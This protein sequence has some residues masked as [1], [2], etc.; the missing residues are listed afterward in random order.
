MNTRGDDQTSANDKLAAIWSRFRDATLQRVDHLDEALIALLENRLTDDARQAAVRE[1]H[2]LAGAS[3]TFGFPNASV[4]ARDL[5]RRLGSTVTQADVPELAE[6]LVQLRTELEGTPSLPSA[7]R[8]DVSAKPRT[9]LLLVEDDA[10]AAERVMMEAEARGF[11]VTRAPAG[12]DVMASADVKTPAIG[13]IDLRGPVEPMLATLDAMHRRFP[14]LPVVMVM[15]G[16]TFR[17]RVEAARHGVRRYVDAPTSARRILDAVDAV[18]RAADGSGGTV[19]AVDDDPQILAAAESVLEERGLRF[20]S[21]SDPTRFWERLEETNPDLL[22]LDIDMPEVNGI[23]ACRVV[24]G[25]ARWASLPIVFLTSRQDAESMQSAFAAGA[26]D[27]LTKPIEPAVLQTRVINRLERTRIQRR[28]AEVDPTT[29]VRNR[30]GATTIVDRLI[31]LARRSSEPLAL[32]IVGLK[33][34][35]DG[36]DVSA[37]TFRALALALAASVREEEVVGAWGGRQ[38]IVASYGSTAADLA[39]RLGAMLDDFGKGDVYAGACIAEFPGD[40]ADT[41]SLAAAARRAAEAP[42]DGAASVRLARRPDDDLPYTVDVAIVDDDESLA[43]L[44]EHGVSTR[45]RTTRW[46]A[47]GESAAKALTGGTRHTRPRLLLLD[48]DL[49][50]LNGYDLLRRLSRDG[51]TRRTKV[52]MLTARNAEADVLAGLEMGAIDHVSKPFNLPVLLHKI[53]AALGEPDA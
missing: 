43:R 53:S 27:Y 7:P 31:H 29:G 34:N 48:V 21:L 12:A 19:L 18:R 50:G 24:R 26:D 37:E 28:Q 16:G 33:S 42:R 1:A 32:A 3:G 4:I 52:I 2:K 47:D 14:S 25:N 49:P 6:Q 13:V 11:E 10:V 15:R 17:D 44:L 20:E 35:E 41:E 9:S 36:R 45:G 46:F 39:A 40:G 23:E 5:E 8:V 30:L 38:L 22:L 51:V